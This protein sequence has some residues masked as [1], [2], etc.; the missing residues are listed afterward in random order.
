M[1]YSHI[2][3]YDHVLGAYPERPDGKTYPYSYTH[4]SQFH[5]PFVLF[6]YLASLTQKIGLVTGVLVLPQRQTALVAKQAA[7]L[8]ILS[9]GRVRLGV[10][11]GWNDV[12]YEALGQNFHDRGRRIEEQIEVMRLLWTQDVVTYEGRWHKITLAG[13]NPLPLQRP[14]PVWMGGMAEP[15]IERVARLADGWFPQIR[16]L[17]EAPAVMEKLHGYAEEAGRD[18]KT[19]GIEARGTVARGGPEDWAA[20]LEAWRD[21]GATH[22]GMNTMNAGLRTPDE[23]VEALRRFKD[24]IGLG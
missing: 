21:L 2:T 11:I 20:S 6:G 24:A 16:S 18:P 10:G 3:V 23:H 17:E 12:E 19:I 22:Y 5:E 7:A 15:V 9:G 13:I 1:G 8:D 14:I 4:E